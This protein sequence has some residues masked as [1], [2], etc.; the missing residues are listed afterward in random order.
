V[1]QAMLKELA[2]KRA[3]IVLQHL[4]GQLQLKPERIILQEKKDYGAVNGVS[5]SLTPYFQTL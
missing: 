1:D 3:E 4:S 2:R 5:I